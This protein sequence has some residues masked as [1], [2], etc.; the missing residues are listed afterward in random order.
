MPEEQVI[1]V[2][3]ELAK[4]VDP[5]QL[6]ET[7]IAHGYTD[8]QVSALMAEAKGATAPTG[9]Q[10][11]SAA[12]PVHEPSG[13]TA[14][15]SV[16]TLLKEGFTYAFSRWDLVGYAVLI[17]ILIMV[18]I[19]GGAFL[20]AYSVF[21]MM[22]GGSAGATW[23]ILGGV[24]LLVG[25]VL[26][27]VIG[28]IN[29]GALTYAVTK[30]ER[31]SYLD[32]FRWGTKHFWSLTWLS[33][34]MGLIIMTGFVLLII[35]GIILSIYLT[36]A[37]FVLVHEDRRGLDALVRSTEL[38]RGHWWGVF[39]RAAVLFLVGF[40]VGVALSIVSEILLAIAESLDNSALVIG[41]TI[42]TFVVQL[43][44]QMML[45]VFGLRVFSRMYH[46]L[47]V[48]QPVSEPTA[49][50]GTRTLY[51]ALAWLG[52]V[53]PI[54]GGVMMSVVLATLHDA[55]ATG[56]ITADTASL[57]TLRAQAELYFDSAG[58]YAGFCESEIVAS[59]I[60]SL[61]NPEF[62]ECFDDDAGFAMSTLTGEDGFY[63]VDSTGSAIDTALPL[64]GDTACSVSYEEPLPN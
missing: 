48:Q 2:R 7:M 39:G 38:V 17:Q 50:S 15:P 47:A 31:P 8:E 30:P 44:L 27:F 11:P 42:A 10:V 19:I 41:L 5:Q 32:G 54:L 24:M 49:K 25:V 55:R 29:T 28:V 12:E 57:T 64:L 20:T 40:I 62:T 63:C 35:P 6:R 1:Y 21:G 56:S 43:V 18:P 58:S 16:G 13:H 23:V 14:L 37:F 53:V 46:L 60:A 26:A 51:T 3:D 33:L 22:D 9:A 36:L 34:L 59:T 45:L 61:Q 52:L 4:G